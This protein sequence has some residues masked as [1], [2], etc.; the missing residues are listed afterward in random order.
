MDGGTPSSQFTVE[1]TTA[2]QVTVASENVSNAQTNVFTDGDT[3]NFVITAKDQYGNTVLTD[4][5]V[6]GVSLSFSGTGALLSGPAAVTLTNGTVTFST[7]VTTAG[8]LSVKATDTSVAGAPAG[9]ST[10][11]INAGSFHGWGL[12]NG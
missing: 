2:T 10:I 5:A 4:S 8:T 7:Q 12:F 6:D 11:A 3:V 1:S 9:S